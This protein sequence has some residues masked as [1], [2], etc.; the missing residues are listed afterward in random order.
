MMN[1]F[2]IATIAC[3]KDEDKKLHDY[4][5][6]DEY[7]R[8]LF[9]I[10]NMTLRE[11]ILFKDLL[12]IS[13]QRVTSYINSYSDEVAEELDYIIAREGYDEIADPDPDDMVFTP[14]GLMTYADL[15]DHLENDTAFAKLWEDSH[16][17]EFLLEG[18]Q[19]ACNKTKYTKRRE[20]FL[21]NMPDDTRPAF[22]MAET[23]EKIVLDLRETLKDYGYAVS[24]DNLE[25]NVYEKVRR[26]W[27]Y[28]ALPGDAWTFCP[29]NEWLTR[30]NQT[31]VVD[32]PHDWREVKWDEETFEKIEENK[33]RR[34]NRVFPKIP[35]KV[36][37]V[38]G[39]RLIEANLIDG[40]SIDFGR[41]FDP[42][43]ETTSKCTFKA[44]PKRCTFL[45]NNADYSRMCRILFEISKRKMEMEKKEDPSLVVPDF[46]FVE[47]KKVFTNYDDDKV[48]KKP[49]FS[50]NGSRYNKS[51]C[52]NIMDEIIKDIDE[53]R[54][55]L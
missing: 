28:C 24:P 53:G 50:A 33:K 40:T 32:P 41:L 46:C 37:S 36:A 52:D 45:S 31:A 16:W 39:K 18:G 5:L 23:I 3:R 27:K 54:I 34:I 25:K 29:L 9:K 47:Y 6:V 35:Y 1:L 4:Y 43:Y 13:H 49:N 17:D 19:D 51:K 44:K 42:N 38:I 14:E 12:V 10:E 2:E 55:K 21:Q 11:R 22:A 15:L 8:E 20:A 26:E 48:D 7:V 30:K